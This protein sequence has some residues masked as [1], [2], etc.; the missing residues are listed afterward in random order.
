MLVVTGRNQRL[1]ARMDAVAWSIPTQVYGFVDNM[2][3]LMGAADLLVTKAGPGTISEAFITGLPLILSGY[4]RGQEAGNV[5]YVKEHRAGAYAAT[6]RG[7]T[8]L[9][10]DWLDASNPILQ[11][12]ARNASLLARPNASLDIA[13]DICKLV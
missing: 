1:R 7:L 3:E 11:E 6:T 4:I 9:A 10:R 13:T 8:T 2:P 5:A 12:L